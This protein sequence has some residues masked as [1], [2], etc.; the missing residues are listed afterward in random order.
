MKL[1]FLSII[2]ILIVPAAE[3][4]AQA[5]TRS[6]LDRDLDGY[7]ISTCLL[8][9]DNTALKEQG[10]RWAGA[11]VQ[12][13]HGPI[14]A[15]SL[16]ADAVRAEIKEK[17]FAQGHDDGPIASGAIAMPMLTCGEMTDQPKVAHAMSKAKAALRRHYRTSK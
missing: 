4:S 12:R 7:A 3:A 1:L 13:S 17:G 2:A 11:I 5:K 16:V 10:G 8:E 9:T 6:A 14:E 15:F